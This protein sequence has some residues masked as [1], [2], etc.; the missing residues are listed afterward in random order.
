MI[1]AAQVL[2]ADHDDTL[3][4]ARG[5][6]ATAFAVLVRRHQAMF[7]SLALHVLRSRAAAEDLAQDVFLELYR[8]LWN[9]E[10]TA[11]LVSWLRRVT[12]HRCIDE[13]RRLRHRWEL[14]MDE[15]PERG[16][17][18]RPRDLFLEGRLQQLVAR[19]PPRARVVMV[20]RYQEE[21]EPSEIA[22]ALQMPVNTVKSHL[23][24]SLA[25]LRAGLLKV[26]QP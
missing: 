14:P 25:V 1:P 12:G 9:L 15:V 18:A 8:N 22:D 13:L 16:A 20:L 3:A 5:G 2:S 19:L 23:R 17:S 7:F 6:D 26:G 21:L 10:S 4:L 11:H 24:R